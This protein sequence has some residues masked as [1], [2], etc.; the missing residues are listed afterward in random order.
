MD[1]IDWS[2]AQRIGELVA[3][4]PPHGGVSA[5]AVEPLAR[6]FAKRVSEYSR[7]EMPADDVDESLPA[8]AEVGFR[9]ELIA[10]MT[11]QAGRLS[12]SALELTNEGEYPISRIDVINDLDHL[13]TVVDANPDGA[14]ETEVDPDSRSSTQVLHRH[15]NGLAPVVH[16]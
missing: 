1:L 2:A 16:C 7:L 9:V 10:P 13:Q 14:V 12:Q 6:D 8:F 3:G 15:L 11:A 5:A 4:S